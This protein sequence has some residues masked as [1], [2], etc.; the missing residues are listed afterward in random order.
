[1]PARALSPCLRDHLRAAIHADHLGEVG[2]QRAGEF[3]RA[4]AEIEQASRAVEAE[5]HAEAG[6]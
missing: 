2:V 1:M 6:E 5:S 3:A 4:A